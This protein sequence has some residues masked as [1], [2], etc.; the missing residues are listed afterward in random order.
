M[1]LMHPTLR[2][3]LNPPLTV[4]PVKARSV[5]LSRAMWRVF[6]STLAASSLR[7]A[8]VSGVM[9]YPDFEIFLCTFASAT[10]ADL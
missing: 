4:L 2:G 8:C 9:S 3:V 10:A 5:P 6:A 7:C 1:V